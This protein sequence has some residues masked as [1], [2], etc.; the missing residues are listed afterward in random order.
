MSE[1]EES[2]LEVNDQITDAVTSE[3]VIEEGNAD[4][5]AAKPTGISRSDLLAK[6]VSY[7]SKM[8]KDT[9]AQAVETITKSP[10]EVYNTVTDNVTGDASGKNKASIKSSGAKGD[11]MA[12]VKE[13][14]ALLFGDSTELSEDFRLQTEALFEAAVSTRVNLEVARIEEEF[15][16]KLDESVE[17]IKNDMVENIDKYLN[18]AVAEWIA[19]NKLEVRNTIRTQMAESF[20]TGL[21]SLFDEHYVDIPEEQT[22]VV[23]ALTAEIESLKGELAEAAKANEELAVLV[24]E[25]AIKETTDA[26]AEGMT[27]TQKDKFAKLV[28]AINYSDADEFR[29]K[30]SIIKET[31]FSGKSEVKVVNDQLLSESVE[32]EPAKPASTLDPE[33]QM[34]V[35][36][37]SRTIKR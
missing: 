10:D 8:D 23:E 15:D 26:L 5:I 27:D 11:A 2:K 33:M 31:Y 20:L 7:A 32:E 16:A 19:E 35:S 34:Y 22:N 18:V 21:K 4:T 17:E 14:L 24:N 1:K 6:M 13:D 28:E 30:A 3:G 9:L 25:K 36:S 37:L 29:K 12:S